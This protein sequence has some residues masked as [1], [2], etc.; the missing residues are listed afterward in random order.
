MANNYTYSTNGVVVPDTSELLETVQAEFQTALGSDLSLEESTPQG[1]LIDTEVTARSNTI[2]FNAQIANVLI[3]ISMSAGVALDAWGANFD[4][5]RNGASS[6]TCYALCTGIAGTIIP[7]DSEALDDNG[8]IW[9]SESEIILD[10]NGEGTGIFYCSDTGEIELSIGELSKIVASSTIGITGWETI[11][12]TTA[13]D[14]G[15]DIESDAEYKQRIL[16][17]IFS[18]SALFGNY[19]S[20]VY[21]V[22]NV[23]DCLTQENPYG[24]DLIFDNVTI[25]EHSVFVCVEGGEAYDVAYA[26]YTVKSA[27]CGWCGNTTVVVTD[28]TYGTSNTVIFYAPDVV[29][30]Q[31]EVEVTSVY[32]SSDNLE[33]EI[34]T[35]IVNYFDNEYSDDYEKIGIRAKVDPFVV[36]SLLSAK[37]ANINVS[38]VKI[39]LVTEEE[40]AIPSTIKA[41]ITSG[42]TWV[43]VDT[44]TFGTAVENANGTYTFT[45]DGTDWLLNDTAI[46]EADYGLTVTGSPVEDDKIQVLYSTGEIATKAIQIFATETASITSDNIT[47]TV[48]G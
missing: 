37:V 26:L 5:A 17:S 28:E 20:A 14:L 44:S 9:K 22:D 2:A 1:R 45:Y 35:V 29:E 41:S 19:S 32:N 43:S 42:V 15:S 25:P 16:N 11:T 38:S 6:S 24:T 21:E 8:I 39:G 12:N 27:G 48:N 46:T 13:A 30:F 47:V 40:H 4:V 18:G 10:D 36:A 34:K 31:M 3:N 7:A 33:D 23:T